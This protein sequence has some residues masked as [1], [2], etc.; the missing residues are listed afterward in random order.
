MRARKGATKTKNGGSIQEERVV[1]SNK[2]CREVKKEEKLRKNG[3]D[4]AIS[5]WVTGEAAD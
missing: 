1:R 5:N 3:Q 4:L 2:H